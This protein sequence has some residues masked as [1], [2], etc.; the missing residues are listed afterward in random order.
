MEIGTEKIESI[1]S[2]KKIITEGNT[3]YVA[4]PRNFARA[5]KVE[6]GSYVTVSLSYDGI[7]KIIPEVQK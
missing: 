2:R 1:E 3:L 6:K 7:L 5:L 4:I